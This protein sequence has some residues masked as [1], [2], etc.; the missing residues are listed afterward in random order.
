MVAPSIKYIKLTIGRLQAGPG[1]II[2]LAI[3]V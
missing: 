3:P 2:S 1:Y